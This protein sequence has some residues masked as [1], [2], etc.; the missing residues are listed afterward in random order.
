MS[1]DF[2]FPDL[3]IDVASQRNGASCSIG[4]LSSEDPLSCFNAIDE[5]PKSAITSSSR[6]LTWTIYFYKTYIISKLS[7]LRMAETS[8]ETL[9]VTLTDE[10]SKRVL[11]NKVKY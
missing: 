3:R 10:S 1:I 11:D 2:A 8:N 4:A 7:F 5:N 6:E 9:R